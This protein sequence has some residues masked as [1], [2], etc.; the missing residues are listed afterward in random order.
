[1]AAATAAF[2]TCAVNGDGTDPSACPLL[3]HVRPGSDV[4]PEH[5]HTHVLLCSYA[6]K[7]VAFMLHLR[8]A[9]CKK[10]TR[11]TVQPKP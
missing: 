11:C 5:V 3:Q 9:S 4:L 1:M 8:L 7:C 10:S 6:V 2:A